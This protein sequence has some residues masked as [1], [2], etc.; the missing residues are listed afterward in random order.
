MSL[1]RGKHPLILASQSRA[2]Q[3]LLANARSSLS[4][5]QSR[6]DA[7]LGSRLAVLNARSSVLVQQ[8]QALDLRGQTLDSQVG[9]MRALGGGWNDAATAR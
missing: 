1:W 2:R 8:R 6:F 5:A 3:A 4:L 9:L 7:G